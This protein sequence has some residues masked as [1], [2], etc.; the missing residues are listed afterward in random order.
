M[1]EVSLKKK[2]FHLSFI[3]FAI[4]ETLI[5]ASSF[6]ISSGFS[7]FAVVVRKTNNVISSGNVHHLWKKI[8]IVTI[9]TF[10]DF[11]K[12]VRV[13]EML[14]SFLLP[15]LNSFTQ[16]KFND[17]MVGVSVWEKWTLF[18]VKITNSTC[19]MLALSQDHRN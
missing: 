9:V 10:L 6:H 2:K 1:K 13:S 7:W 4:L 11:I 8:S 15:N 19:N 14:S 18:T 3:S 12:L 16:F 17:H 5:L